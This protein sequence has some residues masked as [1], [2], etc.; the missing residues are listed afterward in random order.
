MMNVNSAMTT[1]Y[2]VIANCRTGSAAYLVDRRKNAKGDDHYTQQF[3]FAIQYATRE[4][5]EE[6]VSRLHGVQ[7]LGHYWQDVAYFHIGH[8]TRSARS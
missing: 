3:R 4:A 1:T 6:H 2:T 7:A 8:R 5:A